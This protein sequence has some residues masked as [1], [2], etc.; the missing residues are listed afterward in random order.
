MEPLQFVRLIRRRWVALMLCMALG[1]AAGY[2]S[3]LGDGEVTGPVRSFW[4]AGESLILD[5]G[6]NQSLDRIAPN[7]TGGQVP[8]RVAEQLGIPVEE[9]IP[10]IWTVSNPQRGIL[11]IWAV[12]L[13][14]DD[15]RN[16]TQLVSAALRDLENADEVAAFEGTLDRLQEEINKRQDA[17]AEIEEER[18]EIQAR[19]DAAEE[20]A[21][22]P[23]TGEL[24]PA[25]EAAQEDL[26]RLTELG[27]AREAALERL[28]SALDARDELQTSGPG[29]FPLSPHEAIA[30]FQISQREYNGRIALGRQGRTNFN[31][32][33]ATLIEPGGGV[34]AE[35]SFDQ[36]QTRA[37][38]G[39][40]AGLL[41]GV[42]GILI[43]WRLDP[44]LR[45]RDEA[46]AA[47]ALPVITEVPLMSRRDVRKN[48]LHS[49]DRPRSIVS[50]AHRYLR[51][52]LLYA[53]A[54]GD[55]AS[56]V[57]DDGAHSAPA[58]DAEREVRVVMVTSAGSGEG[59][60]TTSANLAVVM[61][62]AG[63]KT[64]LFNCDHRLPRV[65]QLLNCDYVPAKT[66]RVPEVPNLTFI[67]DVKRV[68][69]ESPAEIG[70]RQVKVLE[71][72][73]KTFDVII[74]DTA[75]LMATNDAIDLLGSTD[76]V[77]IVA[78]EAKTTSAA[79]E[80]TREIIDRIGTP[81]AGIVVTCSG[82]G[83]G[84]RYYDS[85]RYGSYYGSKSSK[86][87]RRAKAPDVGAQP[88]PANP[89]GAQPNPVPPEE[90]AQFDIGSL[91]VN[92]NG[93][94][95]VNGNGHH[96]V[97][98]TAPYVPRN[99]HV[100]PT[101]QGPEIDVRGTPQESVW[102]QQERLARRAADPD[103]R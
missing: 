13:S 46:E 78:R 96:P 63:Y 18:N 31:I 23:D 38:A 11:E 29:R 56:D 76:L 32:A 75:P 42:L 26:D 33:Q 7:V 14:A 92:G 60:S 86:A 85:Y 67:A 101:A 90:L 87:V 84:A 43:H 40:V 24:A 71:R 61:A 9:F 53:Q 68:E 47:F 28:I 6:V 66:Q 80:E 99:G 45:N 15:A 27:V 49:R 16:R 12:G 70:H 51:S 52:V 55:V 48:V 44:R 1:A 5:P 82:A 4:A 73:R 103:G 77:V 17:I 65:H 41:L 64:L 34:S 30:P 22:D 54:T 93:N 10:T 98:G 100:H 58:V 21:A 19:V 25:G 89:V 62:E 50:E 94:G 79:A 97:N 83:L 35:S 39:A 57:T 59:K 74:V 72:A 37:V 8:E 69:G 81:I 95:H 3:T 36:P 102:D 2:A 20:L 88:A 91:H